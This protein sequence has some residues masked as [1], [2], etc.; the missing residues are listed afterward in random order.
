[1][2][3]VAD[4][5]S[6]LPFFTRVGRFEIDK[7]APRFER[8]SLLAGEPLWSEGDET[9]SLAILLSGELNVTARGRILATVKMREIVGEASAFFVGQQRTAS[10]TATRACDVLVLRTADLR[11]LRWQKSPVYNSLLD[12]ALQSLVRRIHATNAR[13]AEFVAGTVASPERKE[14]GALVKLWRSF[15]PGGPTGPCPELGQFLRSQPGLRDMEPS[16][17][18]ALAAAFV[19]EPMSEGQVVVLEGE[20]GLAGYILAEGVIDVLRNMRGDRAELLVQ[21]KVGQ[22]FGMNTLVATSARTASCIAATPGWLYRMDGDAY[23]KLTGEARRLWRESILATLA[24]Q[25]AGAN[26]ALDKA[27][28]TAKR[29]GAPEPSPVKSD[30]KPAASA[31]NS[32]TKSGKTEDSFSRLLAASGYLESLP[33]NA[34]ALEAMEFVVD[35]DMKRNPKNRGAGR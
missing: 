28:R 24:G 8:V 13:L 1:M 6:F 3:P 29:S 7:A 19:A 11:A 26:N 33:A 25:I 10:L 30:G 20:P 16:V 12:V 4:E 9:G 14:P 22:Q 32:K 27:M 5:L 31:P 18:A 2:L 23:E 35:E 17:E 34:A 21:L 15:R